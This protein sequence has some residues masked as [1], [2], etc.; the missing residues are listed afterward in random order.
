VTIPLLVARVTGLW[1]VVAC[2]LGAG[3]VIA[4]LV[5]VVLRRIPKLRPG[6][7]AAAYA[8]AFLAMAIFR[9]VQGAWVLATGRP[10]GRFARGTL[11]RADS[12]YDFAH[13]ALL[14]LVAAGFLVARSQGAR[15]PDRV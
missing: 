9:V 14:A 12:V 5:G 11:P 13:A 10:W 6:V 1:P 7:T 15:R 8:H 2:H 4:L 3:L